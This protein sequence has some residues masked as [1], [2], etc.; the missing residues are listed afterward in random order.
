MLSHAQ[1][2]LADGQ[3]PASMRKQDEP[4]SA[5]LLT[6]AHKVIANPKVPLIWGHNVRGGCL[7][8]RLSNLDKC[9]SS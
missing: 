7:W 2:N 8:K 5:I 3:I 6:H 1:H 4:N 9:F